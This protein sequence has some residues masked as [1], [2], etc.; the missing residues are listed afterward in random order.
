[1]QFTTFSPRFNHHQ[2]T[3]FPKTPFKNA[4]KTAKTTLTTANI[5]SE[6]SPPKIRANRTLPVADKAIEAID[7]AK[8]SIHAAGT[9]PGSR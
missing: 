3:I 6:I 5:F 8:V 2:D 9:N 1:M 7:I 4:H